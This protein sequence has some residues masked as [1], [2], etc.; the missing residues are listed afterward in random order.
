MS[1]NFG[2]GG[3]GTFGQFAMNT[4]YQNPTAKCGSA[5]TSFKEKY[6]CEDCFRRQPTWVES[7]VRVQPTP[8]ELVKPSYWRNIRERIFGC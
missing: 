6:G 5:I 7:T 8:I 3:Y 4:G 1:I 2:T